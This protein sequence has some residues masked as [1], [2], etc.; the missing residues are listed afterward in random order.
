MK[1][2]FISLLAVAAIAACTKSE[3]QYDEPSAISFAPVAQNLTKT[4]VT[5]GTFPTDQD[6]YVF[7]NASADNTNWSE[8]YFR[9]ALFVYDSSLGE[10]T[11]P[12]GAYKGS[13]ERYW[14]N[15]KSLKFA[16]YSEAC[17]TP[18]LSSSAKVPT[19]DFTN[20]ELKIFGYIQD[21]TATGL[22]NNDLMWFPMTTQYTKQ[23]KEVPVTMKHACSWITIQVAG[24]NTTGAAGTTWKVTELKINGLTTKGDVTCG[25]ASA[26]WDF[27]QTEDQYKDK[28]EPIFNGDK[29]LTT[30]YVKCET[31]ADNTI[32]LPQA[33]TSID[34]TYSYVSQKG[35]TTDDDTT[36]NDDIVITETANVPLTLGNGT[37]WVSGTHYTYNIKITSTQIL[38]D[39][40]VEVWAEYSPVT[41]VTI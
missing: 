31:I 4:V 41:N 39:P 20:N 15:V 2:I 35:N 6:L 3:V 13:P 1:K 8:A 16:G 32:V 33:P 19:M 17:N 23:S 14:P 34:V 10:T 18:A 12:A 7:A 11:P 9:N 30:S 25:N 36:N 27:T 24:D 28:T 29:T 21:N 22:G 37:N 26:T 40:K 5:D 38:I